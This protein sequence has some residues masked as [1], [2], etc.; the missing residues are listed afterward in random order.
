MLNITKACR[1]AHSDSS[2]MF[3]ELNKFSGGDDYQ[4]FDGARFIAALSE[5]QREAI[6]FWSFDI[7]HF[8]CVNF[9]PAYLGR[10]SRLVQIEIVA[11]ELFNHSTEEFHRRWRNGV[12][13]VFGVE[14]E[15]LFKVSEL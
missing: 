9:I 12:E 6:K 1:Q 14:V 10:L 15:V 5:S 11:G 13:E 4:T 7:C 8:E 3:F 2:L